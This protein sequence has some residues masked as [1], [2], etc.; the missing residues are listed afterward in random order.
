[1]KFFIRQEIPQGQ[2][3]GTFSGLVNEDGAIDE[4]NVCV[5]LDRG[6]YAHTTCRDSFT[7]RRHPDEALEI[8][9]AGPG[10]YD[11]MKCGQCPTRAAAAE[12]RREDAEC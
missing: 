11:V 3:C 7:C 4:E 9:H 1:M 6:R 2:V 10:A 12:T 8:R 5:F